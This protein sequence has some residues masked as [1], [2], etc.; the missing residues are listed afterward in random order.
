MII[1]I[2][3]NHAIIKY[4]VS[5]IAVIILVNNIFIYEEICHQFPPPAYSIRYL[6][7]VGL[8]HVQNNGSDHLSAI[9]EYALEFNFCQ[10]S[11]YHENTHPNLSNI[12]I[13]LCHIAVERVTIRNPL[14][15]LRGGT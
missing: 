3:R 15:Y 11:K 9:M 12:D 4:F 8:V 2:K 14:H 7:L 13:V 5:Y 6:E 10:H 1:Q